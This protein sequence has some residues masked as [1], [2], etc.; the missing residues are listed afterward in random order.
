MVKMVKYDLFDHFDLVDFYHSFKDNLLST[1]FPIRSNSMFTSS[2]F[3]TLLIFV[4]SNVKGMIA[5]LKLFF[6]T[7]NAVRLMPFTQTDPFS[8]TSSANSLGNS[9]TNS[10]LPFFSFLSIQAAVVSTCP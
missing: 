1:Y 10:Q 6:F 7:S 2:P 5:T 4:W 9:N 8:I 3:C